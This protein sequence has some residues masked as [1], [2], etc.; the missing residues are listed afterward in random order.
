MKYQFDSDQELLSFL[1]S[2]LISA[3]EAADILGVCV[4]RIGALVD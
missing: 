1:K 4:R 3:A 2:Q